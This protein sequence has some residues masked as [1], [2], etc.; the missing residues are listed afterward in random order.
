MPNKIIVNNNNLLTTGWYGKIPSLGDFISRRLP[1]DFINL[2]DHW[3]QQTITQSQIQL[4]DNWVN[5]YLVSPIW[6]FILMPGICGDRMWIGI[7]MPSVD[8]I[9]RYFPLTIATPLESDST[10]FFTALSAQSWYQSLE[11]LAL[12]TLNITL[13]PDDI[14]QALAD[15]PFPQ[16]E[17]PDHSPLVDNFTDWWKINNPHNLIGYNA[18]TLPDVNR[19]VEY[20]ESSAE[21][22]FVDMGYGKS[23]WWNVPPHYNEQNEESTKLRCYIGLP[24]EDNFPF[25]PESNVT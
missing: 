20:V 24:N 6:R 8:K 4:G 3:L 16:Y 13:M 23:I 21:R 22:L 1:L 2:W 17:I 19:L 14:D 11:Q 10:S 15:H 25:L 5:H 9:G 12:N 18:A 7:L